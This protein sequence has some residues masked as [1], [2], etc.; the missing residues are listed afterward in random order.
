[1]AK[2]YYI[3]PNTPCQIVK[4]QY[5]W[6]KVNPFKSQQ[7]FTILAFEIKD[8]YVVCKEYYW[9]FLSYK[10]VWCLRVN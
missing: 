8:T 1:M 6:D 10:I 5:F 2:I 7:F 3:L 9:Q 4:S